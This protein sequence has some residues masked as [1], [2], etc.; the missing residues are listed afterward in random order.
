MRDRHT[1]IV[2]FPFLAV[3]ML[4]VVVLVAVLSTSRISFRSWIRFAL[5][6]MFV[7]LC[8]VG[9][10]IRDSLLQ[11]FDWDEAISAPALRTECF[12]SR[13]RA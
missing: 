3:T 2:S 11:P 10:V 5:S 6:V 12:F 8:F 9:L 4:L 1:G 13:H 7:V